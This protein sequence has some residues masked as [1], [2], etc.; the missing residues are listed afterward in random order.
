MTD[1]LSAALGPTLASHMSSYA[2][3][4]ACFRIFSVSP[5]YTRTPMLGRFKELSLDHARVEMADKQFLKHDKIGQK[6]VH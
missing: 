2:V 1:V 4:K 6:L 3:G 5:T